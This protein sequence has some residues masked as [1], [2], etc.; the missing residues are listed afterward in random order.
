MKR[1]VAQLF[2][3]CYISFA[4]FL[5][6][7]SERLSPMVHESVK[8]HHARISA[9]IRRHNRLYYQLDRPEIS[10]AEYDRLFR[11]LQGLET[12]HPELASADSPVRQVGAPPAGKFSP[13][14]HAVPMLSLRNARDLAEFREFDKSLRQTF[15]AG[16]DLLEYAC[17]MKLDGVAVELSYEHGHLVRAST[18]GDGSVGEDITDN[19]RTLTGIPHQLKDYPPLLDVRGEVFIDLA[20]FQHLNRRQQEA[21]EK[22]FANPRNAAAG[23]LR[24]LDA[25]VTASRSLRMYCY[26]VGRGEGLDLPT[27]LAILKQLQ[28]YGLPVNLTGTSLCL[29]P[30][31]VAE[32]FN[33]LLAQRETLGYEIDGMVVKVNDLELQQELGELNRRPRWAIALKFP[34]RQ[35]TTRVE[36][37][38]LQV[39]RTGAITPVAHLEPV[40]ISGVTVSRASLHNWDEIARLGLRSGDSVIVERAG[41]VIPD[42]VK[43]LHQRRSGAE[44]PIPF[45]EWCPECEAPVSKEENEVVPRC[46]NSSCPARTIERLKH[47]VSRGAMNIDGLGEKQLRQLNDLGKVHDCADLYQLGQPDLFAMERMGETLA[48]KL[49]QS[50]ADSRTRPLSRLIFALGIRHVGEQTAKLLARSFANLEALAQAEPEELKQLHEIGDKVAESLCDFFRDPLQ[51]DLLQRLREN[52]V[53]PQSEAV[54]TQGGP[55]NGKS[56]VITGTLQRWSRREAEQRVEHLGGRC[57]SSVSKKTAMVIAGDNAGSKLDKARALGIEILDEQRF[58]ELVEGAQP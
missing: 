52:G 43:V 29:G 30:D 2:G 38:V 3:L 14:R 22:T 32:C 39:G 26:G 23:S 10:D 55:L 51:I 17:E 40:N 58:A 11:E 18:R 42:I 27:Q 12:K 16:V 36:S 15:L 41:D 8:Q 45:P 9:E 56:V 20:D 47:F 19:I 7:F 50:I 33:H 57:A 48:G 49:L 25:A 44:Q 46:T 37:V 1:A 21:G 53:D 31:Q 5:M 35:A 4:T 28:D 6:L 54:A 13:V 34:P 24:Q